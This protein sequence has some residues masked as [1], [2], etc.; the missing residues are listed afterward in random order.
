MRYANED[1]RNSYELN[2]QK[3]QK[4]EWKNKNEV[5]DDESDQGPANNDR[6]YNQKEQ[7]KS[8]DI[9]K[10]NFGTIL[11]NFKPIPGSRYKKARF[12]YKY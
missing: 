2:E 8:F 4:R 10:F 7:S 11:I 6:I 1:E 3:K 9:N 5:G 12:D